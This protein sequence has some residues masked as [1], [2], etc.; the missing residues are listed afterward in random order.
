MSA[1]KWASL[2]EES[3][4][5]ETG[6]SREVYVYVTPACDAIGDYGLSVVAKSGDEVLDS[7]ELILLSQGC[8]DTELEPE[9]SYV[10]FCEKEEMIVPVTITNYGTTD[11]IYSLSLTGPAWAKLEQEKVELASEESAISRPTCLQIS[12]YNF[13]ISALFFAGTPFLKKG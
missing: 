12:T 9:L 7:E 4:S 10:T 8:Y 5:L 1:A 3:L 2:S 6:D 13:T 11:N